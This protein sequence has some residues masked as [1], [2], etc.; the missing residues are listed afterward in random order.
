MFVAM[1]LSAIFPVLHGLELYG[2]DEMRNRIGLIWLV[3]EGFLYIMGAGL[4]AVSSPGSPD[5]INLIF[6]GSLA[7]TIMA[8]L[9]RH[10][11]EFASDL[12]CAC[13]YGCSITFVRLAEGV[14]LP[15][16]S[17]WLEMLDTLGSRAKIE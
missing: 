3:L 1:G 9:F 13:C 15:P 14:R 17:P 5:K 8:R 11:G 6:S 7:R 12:S 10:L 2:A 16:R 4:Y